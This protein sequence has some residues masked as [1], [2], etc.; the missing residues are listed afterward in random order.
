VTADV[1]GVGV[2]LER[3]PSKW[4]QQHRRLVALRNY[5]MSQRDDLSRDAAEEQPAF[6]LHLADVSTDN[7]DRDFALSRI[8][9]EQDAVYEIDHALTRI[10]EGG[11]G[12][13]ELTGK[14]IERARLE[15]IPWA[16]F[17][18]EAERMLEREGAITRTR[19]APR[20]PV[21]RGVTARGEGDNEADEEEE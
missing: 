20:E 13:C 4:K 3:V 12:I 15:A 7:F 14:P 16:R 8:S 21:E 2:P 19:L 9:A 10:R 17:S 11:Y 6:S 18:L 1:I 5:V